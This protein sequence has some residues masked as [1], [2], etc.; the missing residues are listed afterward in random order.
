MTRR[1]RLSCSLTTLPRSPQ[2][3]SST[4][5]S[6]THCKVCLRSNPLLLL[7][8]ATLHSPEHKPLMVLHLSLV[9]VF[10]SRT[11]RMLTKMASTLLVVVLG[12]AQTM[13]MSGTNWSVHSCSSLVVVS[14]PTLVSLHRL[15]LAEHWAL[16]RFLSY[17]STPPLPTVLAMD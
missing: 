9:T 12:L 16:T 6:T 11:K 10:W 2:L 8:S 14:M 1:Q 15:L 4:S 3:L 17:S 7:L 5:R 13:P